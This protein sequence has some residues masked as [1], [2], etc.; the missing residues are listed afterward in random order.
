MKLFIVLCAL[1][2]GS[3]AYGDQ[4]SDAKAQMETL[5][6]FKLQKNVKPTPADVPQATLDEKAVEAAF[7][8]PV[9]KVEKSKRYLVVFTATWCVNCIADK[10]QH[11]IDIKD[12]GIDPRIRYVDI[13]KEPEEWKKWG[14]S[15]IPY[16]VVCDD[17]KGVLW[18]K[19]GRTT[20]SSILEKLGP[21]YSAHA[22]KEAPVGAFNAGTIPGSRKPVKAFLEAA[23]PLLGDSGS[24]KVELSRSPKRDVEYTFGRA[25][26]LIPADLNV[27]WK[28]EGTGVRIEFKPNLTVEYG[29]LNQRLRGVLVTEDKITA[30]LPWCPDP[31]LQVSE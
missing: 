31:E 25:K 17:D 3:A 7:S 5:L 23:R 30:D 21:M 13:D 15:A 29:I 4:Y 9:E 6:G 28:K 12:L 26:I 10:A 20:W 14:G 16:Y 2:F 8:T 24:L 27:T 11:D 1:L 19:Q 18:R 22:V